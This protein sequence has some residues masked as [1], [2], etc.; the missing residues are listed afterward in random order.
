MYLSFYKVMIR[1]IYDDKCLQ[2]VH[3]KRKKKDKCTSCRLIT[4]AKHQVT[5]ENKASHLRM[6]DDIFNL[7]S[8]QVY[9]S[10]DIL[11]IKKHSK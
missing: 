9:L 10:W 6:F 8:L 5:N 11:H 7:I 1:C 4:D 3:K 2:N